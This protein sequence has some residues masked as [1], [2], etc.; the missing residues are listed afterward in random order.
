MKSITFQ[1]DPDYYDG[2]NWPRQM[3]GMHGYFSRVPECGRKAD[4]L[5][6]I[7]TFRFALATDWKP[8][9]DQPTPGIG[10]GTTPT[11][12]KRKQPLGNWLRLEEIR[13]PPNG[14]DTDA[15]TTLSRVAAERTAVVFSGSPCDSLCTELGQ[16][17]RRRG[18]SWRV[19][20]HRPG[21]TG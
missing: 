4:V 5:R 20:P 8:E 16:D 9:R 18:T 7:G 1:H 13:V 10:P 11:I 6:L 12:G 21:F 17:R 19:A 14:R 2:P 3:L 15:D